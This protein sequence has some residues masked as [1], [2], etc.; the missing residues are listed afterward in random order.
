[1]EKP[2]QVIKALILFSPVIAWSLGVWFVARWDKRYK[3]KDVEELERLDYFKKRSR[4]NLLLWFS[5]F[6]A[7]ILFAALWAKLVPIG[8]K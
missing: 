2:L 4:I 8:V 5:G 6:I 7:T 1:M 3:A